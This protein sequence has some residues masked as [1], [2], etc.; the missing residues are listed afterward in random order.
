MNKRDQILDHWRRYEEQVEAFM[1]AL[2]P[3]SDEVLNAVPAD[4]G[5]SALQALHH[6]IV[7]EELG[8]KYTQKKL[9]HDPNPENIGMSH[10]MR[11]MLLQIYL[12]L[13]FAFKAP[14]VVSG[15]AL[16]E[17]STRA[18]TAARWRQIR[19]DWRQFFE[20]LPEELL[21][22]AVFKHPRAGRMGWLDLIAFYQTHFERHRKQALRAANQS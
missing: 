20:Q 9:Q 21:D 3:F 15:E 13:P 1:N 12:R 11:S 17:H 4:G 8:L 18:D 2:E 6:L 14:P 7:I 16:P 22:K 5:W 19:G 10:R